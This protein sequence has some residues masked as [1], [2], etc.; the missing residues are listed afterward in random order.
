[1]FAGRQPEARVYPGGRHGR[2]LGGR[3]RGVRP[4][5]RGRRFVAAADAGDPT[6]PPA[7]CGTRP[8]RSSPRA[9]SAVCATLGYAA[10]HPGGPTAHQHAADRRHRAGRAGGRRA[11]RSARP[12]PPAPTPGWARWCWSPRSC[13]SSPRRSTP[14]GAPT[15]SWTAPT[16]P[17][18][19]PPPPS[20]ARSPGSLRSLSP[21]S[22]W[23]P[24][25]RWCSWWRRVCGPAGG[26][27]ARPDPRRRRQR[28]RWSAL[29]AGYH[30]LA[31]RTAGAGHPRPVCGTPTSTPGPAAPAGWRRWQA[32]VALAL[33]AGAAA[34]RPAPPVVAT[35]LAGALACARHHRHTGRA[36]TALVVPDRWSAAPSPPSTASPRGRH[37]STRRPG[38]GAVAAAVA[39][40]AVGAALVRPLDHRRRVGA[41]RA[42]R[43][44][45][46]PPSPGS[47]PRYQ[48]APAADR[49][50]IPTPTVRPR[51]AAAPGPGRRGRHRRGPAGAR[52]ARGRRR[53]RPRPAGRGRAHR[54][55]RLRPASALA[56]VA[57]VRRQVPQYL[58]YATVGLVGGATVIALAALL[59][60]PA[61]A[62]YAAA[63][64]A[65]RRPRRAD[66]R[67][68][69]PPPPA[70]PS[71]S[72]AGRCCS[73]GALRRLSGAAGRP[74]AGQPRGGRDARGRRCRPRWP[75]AAI[76]PALF[77]ALV[78][79]YRHPPAIWAGATAGAA[80]PSRRRS[81]PTTCWPRCC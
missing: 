1:M 50:G 10:R 59:T 51:D 45:S 53:R 2:R 3:R 56:G 81:T 17:P 29:L 38:P 55:A 40:H 12:A 64:G 9:S 39:L 16:S 23:P 78:E 47:S 33:L 32:P 27:A 65:A 58:P 48:P 69:T 61:P 22:S 36:G 14:A 35:T 71:R 5:G 25:P 42:A 20:S 44:S 73:S 75:L 52:R 34:V 79:P 8:S 66:P 74:L 18:R 62:L 19:P 7:A 31:R 77:A 67:R 37:R 28:R 11:R 60:A 4:A 70:R 26:L 13:S 63:R 24:P 43:A 15:G 21:A 57:A 54:R 46:S 80:H 76:A 41:G 68:A 30:A 6:R 49:R 72:A